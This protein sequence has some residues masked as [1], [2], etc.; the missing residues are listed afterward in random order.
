MCLRG[1]IFFFSVFCFF[2]SRVFA[3]DHGHVHGEGEQ[4]GFDA[5]LRANPGVAS[6]FQETMNRAVLAKRKRDKR[7]RDRLGLAYDISQEPVY[8]LP[9]V[10]HV[11]HR[12][13]ERVGGQTNISKV[14]L[15]KM[16]EELNE[17]FS[18]THPRRIISP[19]FQ[20]VDGGDIGIRFALARRDPNDLPTDGII[21]VSLGG[22]TDLSNLLND[23]IQISSPWD[24]LRYINVWVA[25]YES[26]ADGRVLGAAYVPFSG[27]LDGLGRG[28][29][30]TLGQGYTFAGIPS[31]DGII[32]TNTSVGGGSPFANF[33]RPT[34]FA[35]E[36]GHYLGL[37]H[38]WGGGA[39]SEPLTQCNV[40]DGCPDTPRI[41]EP[42]RLRGNVPC[43]ALPNCSKG[44]EPQFPM[45]QNYMDYSPNRCRRMFS[46]CQRERM[47]TVLETTGWR[48]ALWEKN[49]ALTPVDAALTQKVNNIGFTS[50][51]S[52]YNGCPPRV[53]FQDIDIANYG[54]NPINSI[55]VQFFIG[56]TPHGAVREIAFSPALVPTSRV[57]L[58]EE[59]ERVNIPIPDD[60][61]EGALSLRI[62]S[63]NGAEDTDDD[64][65]RNTYTI[66][67][68]RG[69]VENK[70]HALEFEVNE[71]G[72]E[73]VNWVSDAEYEN[74]FSIAT[75]SN[76]NKLLRIHRTDE[77]SI[78][79]LRSV[80]FASPYMRV[81]EIINEG[82][83]AYALGVRLR[84]SYVADDFSEGDRLQVALF[85]CDSGVLLYRLTDVDA[86]TSH[87]PQGGEVPHDRTFRDLH[88]PLDIS[89]AG[90]GLGDLV[91]IAVTVTN[92]GGSDLFVD[93]LAFTRT[94]R[95]DLPRVD[96]DISHLAYDPYVCETDEVFPFM[97]HIVDY[98]NHG[99]A[100]ASVAHSIQEE[101]RDVAL[102]PY[103]V[104]GNYGT[105]SDPIT[106]L[107][108][109]SS[110]IV[111]SGAGIRLDA[112]PVFA[113]EG[114]NRYFLDIHDTRE[115]IDINP[116]N[117]S[118]RYSVYYTGQEPAPLSSAGVSETFS[119]DDFV[120]VP[121]LVGEGGGSGWQRNSE[122][123]YMELPFWDSGTEKDAYY[124]LISRRFDFSD[125]S[126][127]EF[128]FR[129]AYSG[130]D[131]QNDVLRVYAVRSCGV[132]AGALLYEKSGDAL[133]TS[134][135]TDVQWSPS[136]ANDWRQESVDLTSLAGQDDI[137]IL[138]VGIKGSDE[139]R[140][141]HID[142][143]F[144]S[145]GPDITR[146]RR[147]SVSETEL[148]LPPSTGSTT[149]DVTS[150][151]S[152][153]IEEEIAWLT[154][155]QTSGDGD[156][157]VTLTYAENT[158][159]EKREGILT[160]KNE[161]SGFAVISHTIN[162]S[163]AGLGGRVLSI[164]PAVVN[165][166]SDMGSTSIAVNTN[167]S[168][169]IAEDIAW[170]TPDKTSGD[171]NAT[172]VLTYGENEAAELRMGTITF[173]SSDSEASITTEVAVTQAGKLAL[174][175]P[176]ASPS[177]DVILY[178][179]PVEDGVVS[180]D[181][182]PLLYS[183]AR[184][185]I[186]DF[187]GSVAW[188]DTFSR[189]DA[190]FLRFRPNIARGQA[191]I[192]HVESGDYSQKLRLLY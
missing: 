40:D 31:G 1:S 91:Q 177:Q 143:L 174:G 80:T 4:C 12:D 114:F 121:D 35:H 123:F 188:E 129:V 163:Q 14:Y 111:Y 110:F 164:N 160:L 150:N 118:V 115:G 140:T 98:V 191:Y 48:R 128:I 88:F 106:L 77:P 130:T 9:I 20:D 107:S 54:G 75:G 57:T 101:R 26:L 116:D 83:G 156:A 19:E 90:I 42:T 71:D 100:Y 3:Q 70:L 170:L 180:L 149:L 186:L 126:G 46:L 179:N 94:L 60:M 47:R 61:Y 41:G 117:N 27:Y 167:V 109:N 183:S 49:D 168:W 119:S 34:T 108:R 192:L 92:G 184:V 93:K 2:V 165:L 124:R 138:I 7:L 28:L 5:L 151:V 153:T 65:G 187:S 87:Y 45:A 172:V 173:T 82:G 76:G 10:V 190:R 166:P 171:A 131:T 146:I 139:G 99:K 144:F 161:E 69:R 112:R 135:S 134:T 84:Y 182:S 137:F 29:V 105:M 72:E 122:G 181:V 152:W 8:T 15:E 133:N 38:P 50:A 39:P 176:L 43:S 97:R 154:L 58:F 37:F 86:A 162:I 169:A 141:I 95:S 89:R 157:S 102:T 17:H 120:W 24:Q 53:S 6:R 78:E 79:G 16:I 148:T 155:D 52:S 32:I 132:S 64:Y 85:D 104:F 18:A 127:G 30:N 11:L 68:S 55:R 59:G 159:D 62:M 189:L 51:N 74:A 96:L 81:S 66:T 158:E 22:I 36:V 103:E 145:G 33:D 178:P 142:D 113:T 25:P 56:D 63:V 125:V 147:L 185:R 21:R 136:V 44:T 73:G 175:A 67:V 23:A 13:G